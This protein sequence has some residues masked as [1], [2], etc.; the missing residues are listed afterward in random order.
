MTSGRV[1]TSVWLAPAEADRSDLSLH[2]D[3]LAIEHGTPSFEPHITLTSGQVN[4]DVV[5]GAIE[6]V[7]TAIAP[8]DIAAGRTAHGRDRFKA[9]FIEFDDPRL[10]RL[11]V[12]LS[13][14]L[15]I[16]APPPLR[17]HLSLMYAADLSPE[18]RARIA[19][20]RAFS[21][22][23]LRFD[24]LVAS[25]PGAGIEDIARWQSTVIRQLTGTRQLH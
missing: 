2:I 14:A 6:R 17:P 5:V 9:V 10:E 1:H 7:A 12:E 4:P 20:A 22:R 8:L 18:F 19:I 3:Q 15:G 16:P 13:T 21:G 23:R 24:S 25:V 11:A